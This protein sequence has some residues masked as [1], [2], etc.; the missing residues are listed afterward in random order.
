[1]FSSSSSFLFENI[2]I[3]MLLLIIKFSM[4][5]NFSNLLLLNQRENGS[6]Y[7]FFFIVRLLHEY[8]KCEILRKCIMRRNTFHLNILFFY[9]SAD[10]NEYEIGRYNIKLWWQFYHIYFG[11][12]W[13]CSKE[14]NE[15]FPSFDG[16]SKITFPCTLSR[17]TM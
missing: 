16:A 2:L 3:H 5:R 9:T 12:K 6:C 14:R 13:F 8:Y 11:E 7:R 10:I 4:L 1:M 15:F 17:S